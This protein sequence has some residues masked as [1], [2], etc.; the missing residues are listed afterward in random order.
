VAAK[1]DGNWQNV[2]IVGG[3]KRMWLVCNDAKEERTTNSYYQ[4]PNAG[5]DTMWIQTAKN[6]DH[7]QM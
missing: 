4:A 5:A 7:R 3:E 6:N 2:V 1:K